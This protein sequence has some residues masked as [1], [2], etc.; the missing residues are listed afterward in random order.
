LVTDNSSETQDLDLRNSSIFKC[1]CGKE[2]RTSRGLKIHQ[3]KLGC[4]REHVDQRILPGEPGGS[5]SQEIISQVDNHSADTL[6]IHIAPSIIKKDCVLWPKAND[7]RAWKEFDEE[8]CGKLASGV[9]SGK[10]W[11]S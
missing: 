5:Q 8:V 10:G 6:Q 1:V 3:T 7:C 9:G 11:T 2:V 4:I